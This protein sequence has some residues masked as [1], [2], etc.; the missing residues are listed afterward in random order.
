MERSDSATFIA[1]E[2]L[3]KYNKALWRLQKRIERDSVQ[4]VLLDAPAK[5]D[6]YIAHLVELETVWARTRGDVLALFD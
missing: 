4:G 6:F 2:N 5:R 3:K 1:L